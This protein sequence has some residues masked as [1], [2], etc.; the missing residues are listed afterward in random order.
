MS[1]AALGRRVPAA[2]LRVWLLAA[3]A[4][5]LAA[6]FLVLWATWTQAHLTPRRYTQLPPGATAVQHGVTFRLLA[7]RS[8]TSVADQYDGPMSAPPGSAWVVADLEAT[9]TTSEQPLCSLLLVDD[10]RRSWEEPFTTQ[11][12]SREQED[13]VPDDA[14]TGRPYR[15]ERI[16]LV[17][18][19]ALGHLVGL[20]VDRF[21]V[22][23]LSVLTPA[24]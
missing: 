17:P 24:G 19:D 14:T 21:E 2:R 16:Y 12:P 10:Q 20:A 13:C 18:D 15:I 11:L 4:A 1:L 3:V 22:G 6:T 8:T 23:P 5:L 7:L 9:P